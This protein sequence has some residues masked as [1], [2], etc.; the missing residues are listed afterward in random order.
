[1]DIF[2]FGGWGGQFWEMGDWF[3]QPLGN[4][5]PIPVPKFDGHNYDYNSC[6]HFAK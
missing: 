4:Q 1:M 6:I 5:S 3:A 2:Y